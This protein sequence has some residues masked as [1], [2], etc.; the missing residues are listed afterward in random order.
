MVNTKIRI[1]LKKWRVLT[2]KLF[3]SKDFWTSRSERGPFPLQIESECGGF[4]PA[5]TL[6][7]MRG[8]DV[9]IRINY[10]ARRQQG[11]RKG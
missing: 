3:I 1:S 6:D 10:K 7:N 2:N 5:G 9:V 11:V 8:F 4:Y